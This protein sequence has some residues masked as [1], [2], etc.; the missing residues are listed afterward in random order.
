MKRLLAALMVFISISA[1][2]ADA[3]HYDQ[4]L[5]IDLSRAYLSAFNRQHP[6]QSGYTD[7]AHGLVSSAIAAHDRHLVFVTFAGSSGS[8]GSYVELEL[9]KETNLLTVV[10]AG[11]VDNIQA[12][13]DGV[14]R[15][16]SKIYVASPAVCPVEVP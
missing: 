4:R 13:R 15:V 5:A 2:A 1:Y 11:A 12:Y 16:N 6:T 9:C 8:A 3:F 7:A 14:M 10:E